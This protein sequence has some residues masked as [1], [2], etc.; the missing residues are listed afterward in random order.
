MTN[1]FHT[2]SQAIK[3]S[4]S[5]IKNLLNNKI[6]VG[7]DSDFNRNPSKAAWQS[8]FQHNPALIEPPFHSGELTGRFR[9]LKT[10]LQAYHKKN[11]PHQM[12]TCLVTSSLAGEG[13]TTVA[14]N[15]AAS[16]SLSQETITILID[17][18]GDQG[19]LTAQL[20]VNHLK[21]LIDYL[22][23]DCHAQEI[24]YPLPTPRLFF[25]PHGRLHPCRAE[26]FENSL[27]KALFQ[28]IKQAFPLSQT[29]IDGPPCMQDADCRVLSQHSNAIL[30]VNHIL[31]TPQ[32]VMK[33]SIERLDHK[34]IV[35]VVT[36]N[37]S[38]I[39]HRVA[40]ITT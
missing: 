22:E 2:P 36:N 12:L 21:G 20:E 13:A 5:D 24:I 8:L 18:S 23:G 11:H 40:G 30:L 17:G 4:D 7:K 33:Q 10:S 26:Y 1:D 31:K 39:P 9:Q 28:Y 32:N 14:F 27:M 16:L 3:K 25:V 6:L 19:S 37:D 35:G 38:L 15:L 29:V 34:K